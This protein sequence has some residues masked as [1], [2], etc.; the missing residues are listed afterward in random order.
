MIEREIQS[1]AERAPDHA[2]STLEADIWAGVA[3]RERSMRT[4]KRLLAVQ[5]A[6]LAGVLIGSLAAGQYWGSW[7]APTSLDV[8][9]PHVALRRSAL[10]V[11]D[12][13]CPAR[14]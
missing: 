13:R 1:L 3:E 7:H 6:V 5:A 8:F 14:R 12:A 10:L 2:L 9:Y 4:A 11:G